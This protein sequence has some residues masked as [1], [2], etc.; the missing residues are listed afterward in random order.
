MNRAT[1]FA[2]LLFSVGCSDYGIGDKDVGVPGAGPDIQVDPPSLTFGTLT[3]GKTEDQTFTVTNVGTTTLHVTDVQVG[4]NP[5]A[6]TVIGPDTKFDLEPTES[7]EVGVEFTPKG[8]NENYGQVLVLSDDPDTPK[9]PV[10]LLGYGAVP[11]LEISPPSYVFGDTVVPCGDSIDLTLTNV[12]SEDLVITDAQ[13]T[14]GGLLTFD[15]DGLTLPLTLKPGKSRVV[16][17]DFLPTTGG[18]DTGRLDVTSNDP[19]GV[20]SADQNG[21]GQYGDAADEL[22]TEPGVPP[23]DVMLLIDHS[24][25]MAEDNTDDVNNGMPD[26]VNTL[27]A[28]S[29]WQLIEVTKDDGCANGGIIDSSTPNA[30]TLLVNHAFDGS[31]ISS[32]TEALLKLADIALQ[33]TGPGQCNDGFLR[34]G[35]LLHIIVIS[36]EKEQSGKTYD[37]WLDDY[38]TYV[39]SPDFVKVSGVLDGADQCNSDP[40]GAGA[41]GYLD[42]INATG[43]TELDICNANWG[44]NFSDIASSVLAGARSYNLAQSAVE[45]TIVVTVNGTPTTSWT[46]TATGNTVSVTDPPIGDGDVVEITYNVEGTCH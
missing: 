38:Y 41:G 5:D 12:G 39:S 10:D 11:Q 34:P 2:G 13:Y 28:V 43:G 14:S 24:C 42:A 15:P 4:T 9:A 16:T 32:L 7:K 33:N 35:A 6:F 17:V 27:E 25:S 36:D 22:F 21:E 8:A 44:A 45:S 18:S 31:Q 37:H 29:D 40:T 46:Y 23:V 1:L 3:S 30:A 26:F 19:R 20:Q